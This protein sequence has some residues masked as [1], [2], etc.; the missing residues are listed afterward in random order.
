MKT[1]IFAGGFGT[2]IASQGSRVPKP[3]IELGGKPILWH[4]ME[5]YARQGFD[6]FV[7][8]LGFRA[9]VIKEYFA[10]FHERNSDLTVNLQDGKI[11]IHASQ[12]PEWRVTLVDTGI[13]TMTG[14]RLRRMADHIDAPFMLTYG[15]GL[16][17]VN[18]GELLKFHSQQG[19]LITVTAVNPSSR[20][21]RLDVSE[22][23][24]VSRFEEKPEFE[25]SWVNGGFMVIQPEVVDL[26]SGDQDVFETDTMPRVAGM[27]KMSAFRHTGFW[28]SMD[29]LRDKQDLESIIAA[30]RTPWLRDTPSRA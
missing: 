13:N 12:A 22:A 18:L 11:E 26:I 24:L 5:S 9:D 6:D 21:G 25:D 8:A 1:V 17:D 29:T 16:S 23:G 28:H 15:D 4:I 3:M 20:Y 7:V 27:S 14:G 30:G 19:S 2:R 10:H